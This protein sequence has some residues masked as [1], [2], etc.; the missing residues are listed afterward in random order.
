MW[1]VLAGNW[2]WIVIGALFVWMHTRHGGCGSHH[3]RGHDDRANHR[4]EDT[5]SATTKGINDGERQKKSNAL[6][7]E[8]K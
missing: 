7:Q 6:G 1:D 3:G 4:S 2:L 5:S 8:T